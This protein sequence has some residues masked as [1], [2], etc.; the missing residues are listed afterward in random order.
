MWTHPPIYAAS[1][2]MHVA[3]VMFSHLCGDSARAVCAHSLCIVRAAKVPVRC[4]R[5]LLSRNPHITS[6]PCEAL[7]HNTLPVLVST[8]C[9]SASLLHPAIIF[10]DC[11]MH[12]L[13]LHTLYDTKLEHNRAPTARLLASARYRKRSEPCIRFRRLRIGARDAQIA[14]L[15]TGLSVTSCCADSDRNGRRPRVISGR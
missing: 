4:L 3:S 6:D 10:I 8:C 14:G 5:R 13:I 9:P 7:A 2:N 11:N 15:T 1:G 12:V